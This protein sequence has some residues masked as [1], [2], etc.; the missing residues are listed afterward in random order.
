MIHIYSFSSDG[1]DCAPAAFIPDWKKIVPP[2]IK[3]RR[4]QSG[5]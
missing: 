3:F 5:Y 4:S 1:G 2:G